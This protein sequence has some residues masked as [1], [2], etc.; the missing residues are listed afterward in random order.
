[1]LWHGLV[2]RDNIHPSNQWWLGN[3]YVV[4]IYILLKIEKN[5]H[6]LGKKVPEI[7]V[8]LEERKSH[9]FFQNFTQIVNFLRYFLAAPLTMQAKKVE[10]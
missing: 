10:S 6:F 2:I 3:L 8:K 9:R 7:S 4:S 1:M 5:G